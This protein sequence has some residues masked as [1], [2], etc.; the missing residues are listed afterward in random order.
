VVVVAS[1]T[2]TGGPSYRSFH[3][4]EVL[5]LLAGCPCLEVAICL[6]VWGSVGVPPLTGSEG[7]RHGLLARADHL[8]VSFNYIFFFDSLIER[9]SV[10][11]TNDV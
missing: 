9:P 1:T 10:L 5:K 11:F 8:F 4:S 3:W 6:S 2:L 7:Q